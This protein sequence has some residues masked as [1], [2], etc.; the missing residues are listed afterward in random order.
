MNLGKV[1]RIG[2]LARLSGKT[3]R[4]LHL[5]EELGL[6]LPVQR[7]RGRFRLYHPSAVARVEWIGKLQDASFSLTAIR[8]F[9]DDVEQERAA[10]DA[11]ARVRAVFEAKLHETREARTRLEK[12]EADLVASLVYLDG[13][14]SCQPVHDSHEC[15]ECCINGHEPQTQPLLLAGLHSS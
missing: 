9:L 7:T 8:E 4:A 15:S 13:C 10:P 12:L 14:R 11:M 2:E 6:L 5:Y 3:V 1:L